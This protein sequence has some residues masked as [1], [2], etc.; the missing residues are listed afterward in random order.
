MTMKIPIY[1]AD[2]FASGVFRGNPAAICPLDKWLPDEL[3]QNIAAENNLSETAFIV[4][5]PE[6]YRIRWFTPSTEVELCG[7]AT[8]ATAHIFYEHLGFDQPD[9]KFQSRSGWLKISRQTDGSITLDFPANKPVPVTEI[10]EGIFEG[11]RIQPAPLFRGAWDYL[12]LL[13][14]QAAIEALNPDFNKLA[15]TKGRGIIVTAK[16]DEADFVSRCFYPQCGINE[17][18]VTGSAHTILVPF[19]SERLN[20]TKMKAIQLSSRRGNLDCELAGD[21]VLMSGH[22]VTYMKGEIEIKAHLG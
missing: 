13:E 4:K 20:K 16:G 7:H 15:K 9:L 5:E 19:W 12:V 17:D 6:G 14:N 22:A 11:L 3:M 2:A 10:P 21:R 8:L 1:Q 18:P